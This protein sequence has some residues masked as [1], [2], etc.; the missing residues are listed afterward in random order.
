MM[1]KLIAG[2]VGL[3]VLTIWEILARR[4]E[5]GVLVRKTRT[6]IKIGEKNLPIREIQ[7]WIRPE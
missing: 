3:V 4:R 5:R 2:L 1:I 6:S 7:D